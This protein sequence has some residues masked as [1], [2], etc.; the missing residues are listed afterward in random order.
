MKIEMSNGTICNHNFKKNNKY[1]FTFSSVEFNIE[2]RNLSTADRK[3]AKL[4]SHLDT[5][6]IWIHNVPI[7]TQISSPFFLLNYSKF[8]YVLFRGISIL[9]EVRKVELI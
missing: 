2:S 6:T 1:L 5:D 9:G 8:E 7:K 4:I 3:V